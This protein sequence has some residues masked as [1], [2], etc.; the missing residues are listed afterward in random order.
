[1][2]T[3]PETPTALIE[4]E[5]AEVDVNVTTDSLSRRLPS[6][7]PSTTE[8]VQAFGVKLRH[9][10]DKLPRQASELYDVYQKPLTV[11]GIILAGV[12]V[13][14]IADG[15][16]D[17]LNSIPLV[18]SVLELIGLGYLGW[19]AWRYLRYA[20]TREEL[21]QQYHRIKRRIVGDA[22]VHLD[23]DEI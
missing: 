8:E 17:V 10:L 4:T 12:L 9:Y 13:V 2:S 23:A 22:T 21:V 20:E 3:E 6:A 7:D 14:A 15:I 19:F 5:S 1:M 16:L 18:A 11:L